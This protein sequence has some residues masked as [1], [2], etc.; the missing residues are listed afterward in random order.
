MPTLLE[1]RRTTDLREPDREVV[2]R[3]VTEDRRRG[4]GGRGGRRGG[5]RTIV[6]TAGIGALALAVFLLA[7]AVTGV[8]H[9]GNPFGTTTVDHSPP[10]LLKQLS[11]LSDY[12]AARANLEATIDQQDKVGFLPTFIAGEETVFI[13]QG[14][15]DASVNFSHLG[16]DAVAIGPDNSATI[17]LP[18]PKIGTPYVDPRKSR[19]ATRSRGILDRLGSPFIDNPTGERRFYLAAQKRFTRAARES[20]VVKRAEAN[21]RKMLT[22]FLGKLGYQH[23]TVV[24]TKPAP[25][26]KVKHHA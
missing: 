12:S 7:G 6:M 1:E 10:V 9:I 11:N 23:V 18:T 13:A 22:S 16:T 21:T 3:V 17:T 24:F 14:W 2:V 15:V 19:I 4:G 8:F 20:S 25:A 5:L 26:A